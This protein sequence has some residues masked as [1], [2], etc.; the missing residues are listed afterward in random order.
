MVIYGNCE[1]LKDFPKMYVFKPCYALTIG[2]LNFQSMFSFLNNLPHHPSESLNI[3][4]PFVKQCK[5]S[6]FE[7]RNFFTGVQWTETGEM[8]FYH[9]HHKVSGSSF[10]SPKSSFKKVILKQNWS[11]EMCTHNTRTKTNLKDV[12]PQKCL[13]ISIQ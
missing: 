3:W 11:R 6:T 7:K 10:P 5:A 1:T 8:Y 12:V 2:L 4:H 9:I 13:T